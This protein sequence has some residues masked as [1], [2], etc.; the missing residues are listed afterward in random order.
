MPTRWRGRGPRR[1]AIWLKR[2]IMSGGCA[3]VSATRSTPSCVYATGGFAWSQA[4]FVETSDLTG[5][6]DKAL[7]IRTGF[8][9]GAGVEVPIA[10]DWS[11]RLEYLYDRFG[12]AS[13]A[14]PSGARADTSLDLHTLRLGLN[15]H[16]PQ[17]G[18]LSGSAASFAQPVIDPNNWN[19]HGQ[20]TFI[21]QGYPAF[22]SP[23]QG[24]NSLPAASRSRIP[25]AQPRSSAFGRG[26]ARDL[27]QSGTHAGLWSQRRAGASLVFPTAKRR[28]R[29]S[30]SPRLNVARAFVRQTFG[31]AASRRR[32]RTAQ[33]NSPASRI[34]LGSP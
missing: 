15:W 9:V 4:R 26:M 22:R 24:A 23:Y 7:R 11:A 17:S 29:A 34:S 25:R 19:I 33:T 12:S 27:Y 2:S 6:E 14:L 28:N 31:L 13:A 32:S 1:R 21:G 8:T 18:R 30:R 20:Y 16:L 10:P 5:F 3:A